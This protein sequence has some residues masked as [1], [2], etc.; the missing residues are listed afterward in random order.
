MSTL[1]VEVAVVF[2]VMDSYYYRVPAE[3]ISRIA[4]GRQVL[5][6]FSR[7]RLTGYI[8]SV[9]NKLPL[10]PQTAI[11][12]LLQINS[13]VRYF[14]EA[15]LPFY[16]WLSSYYLAPL[17]KIIQSAM[18]SGVSISTRRVA[19]VSE[20]GRR[21]LTK[22]TATSEHLKVLSLLGKH[23]GLSLRQIR[24]H[25][26]EYAVEQICRSLSSERLIVWS[27]VWQHWRKPDCRIGYGSRASF[28]P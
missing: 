13:E 6:P 19:L 9:R 8:L 20:A 21:V 26:P 24:Q 11:R 3:L 16:R 22:K 25:L 18:P 2:P 5:V 7:R 12:D 1:F 15:I 28:Q 23:A 10:G 27:I 14:T 17:G 4:V